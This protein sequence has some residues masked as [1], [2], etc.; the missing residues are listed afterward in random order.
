MKKEKIKPIP[1]YILEKIKK[2][3]KKC[4]PTPNSYRRFYSYLTKNDGELV[5]VTVAVKEKKGNWYCKQVAV[6]GLDSKH[7][8]SKDLNFFYIGGYTVGWAEDGLYTYAKWW[9]DGRWYE[10]KDKDLDPYAPLVNKDFLKNFPEFKYSAYELY[11]GGEI[12]KFLRIYRQFPQVEYLLKT[13]FHYLATSKMVLQQM[14]KDKNF[15]KWL[16]ANQIKILHGGYYIESILESYKTNMSLDDAQTY[17]E[18]KKPFMF[19]KHYKETKQLIKGQELKKFFVYVNNQKIKYSSYNDYVIACQYLGLDM[20]L[21]KNRYPHNFNYWHD[22]RIDQYATAQ[23]N[24]DKKERRELYSKFSNAIKKYLPLSNFESEDYIVVIAKS[25]A[26]LIREG[27]IL[28]HCVGKM[29]YDQKV[30]KQQSLIFF[31]RNKATP[32]KPFVTVEYSLENNRVIQ[33]HG[34]YN[35][36]PDKKV[37]NFIENQWLPFANKQLKQIAA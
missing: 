24:A 12:L 13:G 1:K 29:N 18:K 25:P 28:Q 27:K 26:E 2:L 9:E 23:A 20:S 35:N 30:I 21:D 37:Y 36:C 31:V 6:H 22:I 17:I 4:N 16:V 5:K 10:Y 19:D 8:Y 7:C 32:K 3:D 33:S 34:K 14:K 11:N 15:H